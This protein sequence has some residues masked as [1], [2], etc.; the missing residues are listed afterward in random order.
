VNRTERS[1]GR[2]WVARPPQ[3]TLVSDPA[4]DERL[5]ER[6]LSR[7]G[8][9]RHDEHAAPAGPRIVG[10]GDDLAELVFTIGER[11]GSIVSAIYR[12]EQ[13]K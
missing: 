13:H 8:L 1:R 12:S 6:G 10:S 4:I 5:H 11:H 9:S 3:H 7:P 2:E